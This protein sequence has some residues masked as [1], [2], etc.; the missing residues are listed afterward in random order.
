M[1][2]VRGYSCRAESKDSPPNHQESIL[3]FLSLV[4]LTEALISKVLLAVLVW[5]KDVKEQM[6][7]G[8]PLKPYAVFM[9]VIFRSFPRGRL[10]MPYD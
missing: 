1:A 8:S 7:C 3:Q 4:R 2:C 5:G 6:Q 9:M 10:I